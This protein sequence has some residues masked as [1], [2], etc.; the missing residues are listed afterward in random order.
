MFLR[1]CGNIPDVFFFCVILY[2]GT[3]FMAMG[4]RYLKF[5][6]FFPT[7]IRTLMSNFAVV[8]TI[9]IMIG[10]DHFVGVMPLTVQV[11]VHYPASTLHKCLPC[12]GWRS[13]VQPLPSQPVCMSVCDLI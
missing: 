4:L 11:G 9:I 7:S 10:I 5:S 6:S 13:A 2:L 1:D 8:L 3:F 12:E